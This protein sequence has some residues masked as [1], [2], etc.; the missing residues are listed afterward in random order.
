[1]IQ[2]QREE[3]GCGSVGLQGSQKSGTHRIH[4]QFLNKHHLVNTRQ[5]NL[6]PRYCLLLFQDPYLLRRLFCNG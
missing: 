5:E 2:I 4:R 1:M 3:R 6:L